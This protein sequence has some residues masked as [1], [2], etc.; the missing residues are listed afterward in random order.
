MPTDAALLKQLAERVT[1]LSVDARRPDPHWLK[2]W[3]VRGSLSANGP[4][5]TTW[6]DEPEEAVLAFV[7]KL[8]KAQAAKRPS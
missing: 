3:R 5:V 4:M 7:D 1:S 6:G 8:D 2:R